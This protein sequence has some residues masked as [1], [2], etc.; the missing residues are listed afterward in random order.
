M[1]T[2]TI[3]APRKTRASRSFTVLSDALFLH[4]YPDGSPRELPKRGDTITS[5][6]LTGKDVDRLIALRAIAPLIALPTDPDP[7]DPPFELP[8]P[9]RARKP[10][11]PA[12][13]IVAD[14]NRYK[15]GQPPRE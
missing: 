11:A 1:S 9:R 2:A 10:A 5:D 7:D 12:A 3:D 6:E 13:S 4:A 8:K 14:L 15:F